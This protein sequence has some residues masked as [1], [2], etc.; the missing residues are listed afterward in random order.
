MKALGSSLRNYKK[1]SKLNA[2]WIKERNHKGKHE[3][4]LNLYKK[5]SR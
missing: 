3:Y 4:Q 5:K 1:N 2:K